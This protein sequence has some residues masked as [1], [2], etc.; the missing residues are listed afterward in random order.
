MSDLYD[1]NVYGGECMEQ[2]TIGRATLTWLS[3]G[4]SLADGD[5]IF[6]VVPKPLWTRKYPAHDDYQ[7]EL[8]TDPILVQLDGKNYLIDS[9]GGVGKFT[10]KQKRNFAIQEESY[11]KESLAKL[12][13]TSKDI[14][15]ILMT[16]LHY[17]HANG[18]TDK[19]DEHQFISAYPN[20][21]IYTSQIEWDEMRY[22]NIRS[23]NTYWNMN[24]EPIVEQVRTFTD[25]VYID[26][27]IRMV[28]TGGHSEGHSIVLFEDGNDCFI[29]MAD[30]MATH[31]HYN[32]LW[33]MAYDD[34][35]ITSIK[36]KEK[37]LKYGHERNA[38]YTF[39]HDAYYRAVKFATDGEI[40]E[41]MR[42]KRSED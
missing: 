32:E 31:G 7:I 30:L 15:A 23:R 13:L 11:V 5:A 1:K 14:D 16:H 28:H 4:L 41:Y 36:E 6:G 18:L 3:G 38:W 39:Y 33:V 12:G 29:H 20:V 42:R 22:P 34:Y 24:W 27:Y 10:P 2:L 8:R 35:P 9:G 40:V 21:P 17:D 26:E 25:E 37:W 19:V